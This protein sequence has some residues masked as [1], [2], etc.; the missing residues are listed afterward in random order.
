MADDKAD[1]FFPES[2]L[3]DKAG[4][5]IGGGDAAFTDLFEVFE[6]VGLVEIEDAEDLVRIVSEEGL[7]V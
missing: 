3:E 5:D 1:G 7:D 6:V 4:V 2:D